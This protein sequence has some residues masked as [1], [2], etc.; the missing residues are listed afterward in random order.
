MA[1][2]ALSRHV[3]DVWPELADLFSAGEKVRQL[4]L[5]PGWDAVHELIRREVAA[6]SDRLDNSITP[7]TQAEYALA[8]GRRGGLLALDSAAEAIVAR[9]EKRHSEQATKHE[10]AA[11]PAQEG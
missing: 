3:E 7:L 9:A 1:V 6:I 4:T 11:E 8:H 10:S 2:P 5:H